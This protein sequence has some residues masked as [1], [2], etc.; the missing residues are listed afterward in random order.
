ME[1]VSW[2]ALDSAHPGLRAVG[3]ADGAAGRERI[4]VF[5]LGG[6]AEVL[7]EVEQQLVARFAV[8]IVGRRDGYFHAE[9]QAAVFEQIRASGAAIVTVAPRAASRSARYSPGSGRSA[10]QWMQRASSPSPLGSAAPQIEHDRI[11]S[12]DTSIRPMS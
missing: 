3:S 11:R 5:L 2:Y 8:P 4:P 7:A 10:P 9:E 6:K 12:T 1:K